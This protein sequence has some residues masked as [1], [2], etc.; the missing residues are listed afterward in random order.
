MAHLGSAVAEARGELAAQATMRRDGTDNR[1]LSLGIG[2]CL[3]DLAVARARPS[4]G[5]MDPPPGAVKPRERGP[6]CGS[7]ACHVATK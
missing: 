2:F 4:A 6:S 5:H 7:A 3:Q 1:L